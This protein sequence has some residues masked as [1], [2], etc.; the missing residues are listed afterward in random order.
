FKHTGSQSQIEVVATKLM[1]KDVSD[2]FFETFHKTL[3]ESDF[4]KVS[5]EEATI[6]GFEGKRTDYEFEH[7]GVK[8]HV[9]V[10]QFLKND[11]AWLVVG[12]IQ[13]DVKKE[14]LDEFKTVVKNIE[15]T[16]GDGGGDKKKKKGSGE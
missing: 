8:L 14:Y 2:V 7:S 11:T 15:F 4:K 16:G 10:F 3:K 1:T 6:A 5:Q 13:K 12:Y 9:P